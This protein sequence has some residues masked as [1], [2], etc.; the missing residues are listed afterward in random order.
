MP[1]GA[2]TLKLGEGTKRVSIDVLAEALENALEMLRS[3]GQEFAPAGMLVRWEV[4]GAS[5]RS[6]LTLD[7]APSVNGE[8]TI[9]A[10]VGKKIG[11]ACVRG[12]EKLEK[13]PALPQHFNEE[14]ILAAQKLMRVVQKDGTRIAVAS[15]RMKDVAPTAAAVEHI[16]Q[17]VDKA[18]IYIDYGT[19]EGRLEEVSVHGGAHF[20]I[21][22]VLTGYRIECA[23]TL[24]RLEEAK[25]L[26]GQRVAV[27][28]R[29]RYRNHI[30]KS[31]QVENIRRLR[32]AKELPQLKD[33]P[34]IDITGGLSSEEYMRRMRDAQ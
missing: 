29:V 22:E 24:E 5:L 30:P 26:L 13:S 33:M 31:I 4:V 25:A 20:A 14:G 32:D 23:V 8:A 18:R 6:P 7:F 11:K 1:A 2:F 21:W 15:Y 9:S 12:L 17:V 28:G 34:A 10:A 19:I 27:S 16:R 3:V